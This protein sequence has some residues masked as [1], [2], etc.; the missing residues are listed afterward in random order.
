MK[1]SY[2]L[3]FFLCLIVTSLNAQKSS[4]YFKK[5][6]KS[7]L[8]TQDPLVM[9]AAHRG[10]HL[11]EPENSLAALKKTIE[12]G[13]DIM[14]LDVR[15]T[16]DR[17]MVLMHDKKVDRTTNAKGLVSDFTF[18]EIRKLRLKH[19]E[20]ITNEQIPTLEE[21]FQLAK[22]KV[23]IDLDIKDDATLDSIIVLVNRMKMEKN[24]FFFVY[25]PEEVVMLQKKNKNF[26]IMIRTEN[27][28]AVKKLVASGAKPQ[29]V[30][31]DPSHYTPEVVKAIQQIPARVW[32]NALGAVDFKGSQQAA[33]FEEVLKF[34][35][36][37]IQT[38][39]P[40]KLKEYLKSQGK[41]R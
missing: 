40:A 5:I 30:H 14:E 41:Y 36:N 13:V 33:A 8:S 31:I 23:L 10:A 24:C 25:E 29:A 6:Q 27:E 17:H 39:Q 35:A 20:Q 2:F 28:E 21:A 38:D 12:L 19:H 16:K 7:Y 22:G 37:M 32:I 11:E 34:G 9:I 3:G 26:Q 18:E 1:T 4:D 15:F